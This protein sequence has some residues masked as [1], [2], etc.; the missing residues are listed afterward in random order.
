MP[1]AFRVIARNGLK[2]TLQQLRAF[3]H[4]TRFA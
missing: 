2:A 4:L 3:G 1:E